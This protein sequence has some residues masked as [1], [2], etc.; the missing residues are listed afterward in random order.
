VSASAALSS[1]SI[2]TIEALDASR[3]NGSSTSRDASVPGP[4]LR[5][6]GLSPVTDRP[7]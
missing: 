6:T 7:P 4:S 1:N 5:A 2:T 3:V